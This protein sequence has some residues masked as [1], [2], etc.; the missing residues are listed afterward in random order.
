MQ[1]GYLWKSPV[2]TEPFY[3]VIS[4]HYDIFRYCLAPTGGLPVLGL[5][6]KRPAP[7]PAWILYD[8]RPFSP[9]SSSLAITYKITKL[10]AEIQTLCQITTDTRRTGA[11]LLETVWRIIF[12][13][14]A[15]GLM[16]PREDSCSQLVKTEA[17]L[18]PLMLC[19]HTVSFCLFIEILVIFFFSSSL[20]IKLRLCI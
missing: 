16:K 1:I 8:T 6:L 5:R 4:W 13:C 3:V 7:F 14:G 11:W 2:S 9:S 18:D 19:M 17:L 20:Y 12:L 15:D 10:S